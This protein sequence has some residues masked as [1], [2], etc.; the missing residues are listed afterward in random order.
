MLAAALGSH[1][2]SEGT[3]ERGKRLRIARLCL[4]ARL[5]FLTQQHLD[6]TIPRG[7][8]VI[9]SDACHTRESNAG[10]PDTRWQRQALGGESYG[11]TLPVSRRCPDD[12]HFA[13]V[14]ELGT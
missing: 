5:Q 13:R 3:F 8:V 14:K 2:L 7:P 6:A 4:L 12:L 1:V 11:D 9:A 10:L